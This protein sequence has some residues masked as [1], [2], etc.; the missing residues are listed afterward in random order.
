MPWQSLARPAPSSRAV[1]FIP[2]NHPRPPLLSAALTT[3]CRHEGHTDPPQPAAAVCS[4]RSIP[5]PA[6]APPRLLCRLVPR[7]ALLSPPHSFSNSREQ[8]QICGQAE[9]LTA[10]HRPAAFRGDRPAAAVEEGEQPQQPLVLRQRD[11]S[12]IAV[13][14]TVILLHP[15]LPLVGVSMETMRE[16]Q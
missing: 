2:G 15:F 13:G 7:R 9:L 14:E 8:K 12:V 3:G 16:C 4:Q 5:V 11:A 1:D 6:P 10:Q